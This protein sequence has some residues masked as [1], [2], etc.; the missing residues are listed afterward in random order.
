[1]AR[2]V[3]DEIRSAH[4]VR[5]DRCFPVRARGRPIVGNRKARGR[6]WSAR[7]A[8]GIYIRTKLVP[9]PAR[10]VIRGRVRDTADWPLSGKSWNA[11]ERQLL[12]GLSLSRRGPKA[13]ESRCRALAVG[14][15]CLLPPLSSGSVPLTWPS[16]V[17]TSRPS[18]Q[19]TRSCATVRVSDCRSMRPRS[20]DSRPALGEASGVGADVRCHCADLCARTAGKLECRG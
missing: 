15:V 1:M 18:N 14:L 17:S 9:I 10:R 4:S 11:A 3:E 6:R 19:T 8:A 5:D 16:S 2:A 20:W 13:V 12:A 7:C